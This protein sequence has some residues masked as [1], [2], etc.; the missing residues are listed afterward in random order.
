MAGVCVVILNYNGEKLLRKF[1]P[2]VIKYSTEA[3]VWVADNGST[4]ESISLLDREFPEVRVVA[5]GRN[6][7]FCKG[8]NEALRRIQAD[9]YVLLNSD[10]MVTQ[11]WL[12]PMLRMMETQPDIEAVQPKILS[13]TEP[14][15]FEHA[16]AGGGLLDVLG[17]PFCRGRVFNRVEYD[18]G[19]YDDECEVFWSSGAC[20]A[21]RAATYWKHGGLD[22]DFFAHM[23]EIDLCWKI[24][25]AGGKVYYS[26]A[27]VV[28]HLGAGT[29]GYGNPR[30]TY[31]N[32][33]NNMALLLKHLGSG[34]VWW[35]IPLRAGL[36]WLAAIAFLFA[37]KPAHCGA[38]FKAHGAVIGRLS[39]IM[40][41][42]R[43]LRRA[44]P[45][46]SRKNIYGGLILLKYFF[47]R[48]NAYLKPQ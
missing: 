34:E 45:G 7:G 30:K 6:Y 41:K 2:S 21:I 5:L 11:D 23:E 16:G 4:D 18:H 46:Y 9:V 19:Q 3:T 39:G 35:K 12:V 24:Q 22:E 26:G 14:E 33:R 38:V 37:G 32:F 44:Y 1:L 42:R 15:K 13:Y 27:S 28:Y 48:R 25:R 8:Y 20:M 40:R 43:A 29:L 17:Y 36:D 10:V 31:L 47:D